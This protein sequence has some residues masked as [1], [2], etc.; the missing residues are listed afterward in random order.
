M[1]QGLPL[2]WEL[3]LRTRPISSAVLG[4]HLGA[5]VHMQTL[6]KA[7]DTVIDDSAMDVARITCACCACIVELRVG[8]PTM[9]L[10][11]LL[12]CM[13]VNSTAQLP[14]CGHGPFASRRRSQ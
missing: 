2:G 9:S 3:G 10:D 14:K 1:V 4:S 11:L 8:C 12:S 7:P 13:H 6:N 5:S